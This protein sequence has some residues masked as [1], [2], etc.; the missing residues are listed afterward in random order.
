MF[1][2][3]TSTVE[4]V[5][6]VMLYIVA[7]SV[8]L[9]LGI[10]V[11]MIY[12]VFKY[13]RKKGHEPQDIHGSILLETIWIAVPT[14]LVL[15]M[16]YF[17]YEGFKEMRMDSKDAFVIQVKAKMWAWD[18]RYD[19][20]KNLD[21]LYVPVGRPIKL[22]LQ[23]LDVNHSLYIPAFRIKQDVIAGGKINTLFFTPELVGSYDIA[24]AEFCGLNHSMMYTK[25]VVLS[26][27]D[28]ASWYEAKKDSS[29]VQNAG[30]VQ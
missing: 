7:I 13:N 26:K 2:A 15:S 18:F 1:P 16:F 6:S 8:I 21:T 11:T 19:N 25:V 3:P 17:G 9:L 24:C 4:T 23:S 10:T 20:G 14:V 22:E 27:D 30:I 5:D 28:F 12:F 29:E